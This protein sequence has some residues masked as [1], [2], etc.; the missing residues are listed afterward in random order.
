MSA[1]DVTISLTGDGSGSV[2]VDGH[3]LSNATRGLHIASVVGERPRLVLDVP[4]REAK[5]DGEMTVTVPDKTRDALTALGWGTPDQ[6]NAAYRERARLV[7]HLAASYPGDAV[8]A[9]SDPDAPG[10]AVLT[11]ATPA[12]QLS[13]H[14]AAEDLDLFP[15]YLV[16]RVH[17]EDERA[18]WDGHDT[19]TKYERLSVLASQTHAERRAQ[20][21]RG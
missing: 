3:D 21:A 8:L 9:F 6:L 14:I 18:T 15:E 11:I 4:V 17:P 1:R 7:A 2:Q 10:W 20:M 19:P 13:W 16:A 5:V 12:G